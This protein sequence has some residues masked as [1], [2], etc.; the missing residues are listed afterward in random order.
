M[1][2]TAHAN[3]QEHYNNYSTLIW[4]PFSWQKC[5]HTIGQ[6]SI[7]KE[8]NF[9]MPAINF[10]VMFHIWTFK[11]EVLIYRLSFFLPHAMAFSWE[12]RVK[13]DTYFCGN[14][15]LYFLRKLAWL[16]VQLVC[17]FNFYFD[18]VGLYGLS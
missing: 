9:S 17:E 12:S 5:L 13:L 7:D 2:F 11:S 6:V 16:R 8:N 3:F 10:R 4:T 1:L 15:I 18:P 14:F